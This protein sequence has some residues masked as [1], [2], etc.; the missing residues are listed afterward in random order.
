M[1][2]R[3]NGSLVA[4]LLALSTGLCGAATLGGN[5]GDPTNPALVGSDL[6]APLFDTPDDIADNVAIYQVVVPTDGEL[7]IVSTGFAAGGIDPYF[8]LFSGAGTTATFFASN[9]DQAF[10]T[11]GDFV[12]DQNVAAGT[13]QIA[14][15]TFAN[16]SFAE[17][18]GAGTLADGFIQLGL[19]YAMGDGSYALTVN[20]DGGAPPVPEPANA[21]MLLA[22]LMAL[23]AAARR[24]ARRR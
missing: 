15:G 20:V 12:F 23:G 14:L 8:T 18:S 1:A 22:G 10:S 24:G 4:S 16:M 17:N 11:G 9:Y 13:Y 3:W 5:L 21:A 6:G 19:T 7:E 2:L